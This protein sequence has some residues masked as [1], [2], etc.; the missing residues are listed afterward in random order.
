M[1]LKSLVYSISIAAFIAGSF[2]I[3]LGLTGGLLIRVRNSWVGC[4]FIFF[5]YLI[6]ILALGTGITIINP[7]TN[8][9]YYLGC[10]FPD[11]K[12]LTG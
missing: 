3:T 7:N 5:S 1:K 2:T 4:P 6:G 9:L 8:G 11:K 10:Y 12:N